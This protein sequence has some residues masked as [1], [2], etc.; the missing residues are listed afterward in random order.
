MSPSPDSRVAGLEQVRRWLLQLLLSEAWLFAALAGLV[1]W[2]RLISAD[3]FLLLLSAACIASGWILA[4]RSIGLWLITAAP[5]CLVIATLLNDGTPDVG[6]WIALAVSTGHVT[7]AVVLLTPPRVGIAAIT[8]GTVSLGLLWGRRPTNVVPGALEVAGG[9]I[10]LVSLA[11]SATALW[12][13]W[14]S[15]LRQA[16]ADDER[17]ATIVERVQGEIEAQERSRLWRHAGVRVHEQLL[18]TLRYVLQTDELDREGLRR[19][20]RRDSDN[21]ATHDLAR[22]VREA[23]AARVAAGIVRADP[24]ALELDLSDEV[25]VAVRAAIVECAL[26][27]VLH[28]GATDV[29]VEA[30]TTDD[31]IDIRVSDNGSGIPSGVT[32]GLGWTTTLDTGL[33]QVGGTWSTGRQGERT[34]IGLR[35]PRAT[36]GG[37]ATFT[38]DGFEQGRILITTPLAA[39][40]LVGVAFDVL[41]GRESA[42][43]WPL[44]AVAAIASVAAAAVVWR[45]RH[46]SILISSLV[47][48]GLAA[49][50]WLMAAMGS[51]AADAPVQ[52]A[53]ATA[54]GYAL[55]AVGVW[56]RWWQWAGGL[57]L[58]AI[59][60]LAVAQVEQ[61]ESALPIVVAL[62]NCLIIV[63]VV[64]IVASIGTRRYRRSQAALTLERDAILREGLRAN[65]ARLIDQHLTACVAQAED[66][67]ERLSD[68]AELDDDVRRE[69]GCLEGL[70]RATIQVDPVDAGEFTRVAAR[71][72]NSAF[73]HGIPAQVGTLVSSSDQAS[74]D[75]DVVR[76]LEAVIPGADHVVVR[77][78]NDGSHDH[79]SLEVVGSG[80]SSNRYSPIRRLATGSVRIDVSEEPDGSAVIMVSRPISMPSA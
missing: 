79:L 58:W 10:S 23:T 63:P 12:W 71:L 28:G 35:V 27:A 60:V 42:S 77:T 34:V 41:A 69:I 19:L 9:W 36:P 25:R 52:A 32:P 13:V 7:Y 74:L 50:P 17:M 61:G 33:A 64:V 26:N 1:A 38:E 47:I 51:D 44:I 49:N 70:I 14:H 30:T 67:M 76:A 56:S 22:E 39:I 18:S 59:G 65:S 24:S 21:E 11:V 53:G 37:R 40:G 8:V 31:W 16:I 4:R 80:T 78:L 6:Q 57:A 29:L 55:I 62:V 48:L 3:R 5:L 20:A 54:A 73:S 68:G 72:V 45:R 2:P 43:G 66:L 15:L 75:Q 46:P